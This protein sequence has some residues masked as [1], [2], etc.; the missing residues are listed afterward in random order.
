M[1]SRLAKADC[2]ILRQPHAPALAEGA[3][4]LVLPLDRF[5]L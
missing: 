1:I 5:G 3:Q 2:L 4:V